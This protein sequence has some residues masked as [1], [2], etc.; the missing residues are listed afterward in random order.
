MVNERETKAFIIR[1]LQML[2]KVECIDVLASYADVDN[3]N[4]TENPLQEEL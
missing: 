2:G 3:V 1:Q 4:F